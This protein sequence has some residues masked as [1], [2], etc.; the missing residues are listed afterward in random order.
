[1][2]V[3]TPHGHLQVHHIN[4]VAPWVSQPQ[5]LIFLNGVAIDRTIW[6]RWIP[7]LI[8]NFRLVFIDTRGFGGSSAMH[9]I[10]EWSLDSLS[11]DIVRVA[12]ALELSSFHAIG[13]S[14]GG[15]AVLNLAARAE[16]RLRSIVLV[17]APHRG[18]GIEKVKA[19]RRDVDTLG[20]E[21]WSEEMMARRFV[22]GRLAPQL[23]QAFKQVQDRTSAAALLRLGDVLLA[24]DLTPKLGRVAV[25]SLIIA[26]DSSPF[27]GTDIPS[28][29][30]RLLP[31]SEL[32]ILPYSR[33]GI[34]FSHPVDCTQYLLRFMTRNGWLNPA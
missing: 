29:L 20:I 19:W 7:A 16:P 21:G 25:P 5:T 12:D 4:E 11:D 26:P 9:G 18:G 27:V 31:D 8:E 28:E 2:F 6:A 13:E 30:H 3:N 32:A 14:M 1:M 10:D 24:T 15:T 22:P 23:W 33:H 17:S 34:P